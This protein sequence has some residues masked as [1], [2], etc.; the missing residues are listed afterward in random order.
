MISKAEL[1]L[2]PTEK[3]EALPKLK[4]PY[5]LAKEG[6]HC[7][8]LVLWLDCDKEGENICFE[9]IQAVQQGMH[10][11]L[12][13][14]VRVT[15]F[16]IRIIFLDIKKLDFHCNEVYISEGYLAGTIF[17]YYGQRYQIRISKSNKT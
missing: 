8:Y 4:I 6:M 13:I 2:C 3:K 9:V 15:F 12:H 1:F 14:N 5:L 7:D 10:R 16:Y 11:R 17:C